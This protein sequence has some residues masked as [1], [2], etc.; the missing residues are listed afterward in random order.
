MAPASS[1]NGGD[2]RDRWIRCTPTEVQVRAYYFP[3]GTKRIPYG[4]I[5]GVRRVTMG[6]LTGRA[7]IWGSSN[8]RYWASLDP[9]R[10][11]KQVGLILDLGR[12]VQPFI[13]PDDPDAA[14]QAIRA[15]AGLGPGDEGEGSAPLV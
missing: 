4:T 11:G 15:R 13:T 12:R 8:P 14:E 3:W 6:P 9:R 1:S 10:P 7:R 5:K 2:Y